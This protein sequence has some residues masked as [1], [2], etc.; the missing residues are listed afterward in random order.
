M[1]CDV[2]LFTEI[3]IGGKWC[4]HSVCNVLRNYDLFGKMAG[5][6]SNVPPI[7]ESKGLPEDVGELTKLYANYWEGDAHTHSWLSGAEIVELEEWVLHNL[8]AGHFP[9]SKLNWG[10]LFG[11]SWGG[12]VKYPDERPDGVED[13]RFVFWFDN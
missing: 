7:A 5:V 4:T 6:R 13:V 10:Y 9:E 1:G 11:N 3:K 2:H 12:F 8:D